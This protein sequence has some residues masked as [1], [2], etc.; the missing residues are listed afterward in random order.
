MKR[1]CLAVLLCAAGVRTARGRLGDA[2]LPMEARTHIRK[3]Q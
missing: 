3:T 2:S 1:V